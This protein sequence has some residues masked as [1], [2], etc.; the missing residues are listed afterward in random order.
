MVIDPSGHEDERLSWKGAFLA[1]LAFIFVWAVLAWFI[2]GNM[3][4]RRA[5][6][7]LAEGQRRLSLHTSGTSTGVANYLRLLHGI[8]AA[9]GRTTE[10]DR[11]LKAFPQATTAS[12][13]PKDPRLADL[14]DLL[15]N[16]AEALRAVSVLWVMNPDG[17]CLAA[18]NFEKGDSFVGTSYKD[19]E[20]FREAMAGEA[21]QQFAVGRKTGVPGLFFSSP[22]LDKGRVLGVIAAKID[23]PVL[24]TWIS[25]TDSFLADKHGII[26]LA[27][28][29]SLEFRSLPGSSSALLTEPEKV[30]RYHRSQFK[31]IPISPWGDARFPGLVRFDDWA[32]P[33]LM[34][35]VAVPEDDLTVNVLVPVPGMVTVDRDRRWI[36]ALLTLL[37]AAVIGFLVTGLT[38]VLHITHAR[39]ILGRRLEELAEAASIAKSRFLATMSHEIRTPLNGVLGMADLL[40]MPGLQD[41]ERLDYAQTIHDSGNTLL[42]LINDILDLSKVEAGKMELACAPF[43][44]ARVVQEMASLFAEMAARK[45]L[46]LT[47]SWAST[48]TRCYLGDPM[49]LRQMLSNLINNAIKFTETGTIH[50]EGVELEREVSSALLEFTVTDTGMGVPEEKRPQLFQA[51]QQLDASDTRQ[52]AG[53]GLGLSIVRSLARLMGGD[54]T[55]D[56]AEGGGSLFRIRIR[57][58]LAPDLPSSPDAPPPEPAEPPSAPGEARRRILLV[59]DN[60]TNRKVIQALLHR[61]GYRVE[62]AVNG[63]EALDALALEDRPDLVLMDCQMPVLSGFDATEAIR[64]RERELGQTR[65]PIVALTAGAFENDRDHCLECGMD[66]FVTKPVDFKVLP[67]VIAKWLEG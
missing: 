58:A 27:R 1:S 34:D 66:D 23:L 59:E 49:R 3:G 51:F 13:L 25:Q 54:V 50:L 21:G 14:N 35:S 31:P 40:L 2:T 67:A 30:A 33:V 37:G 46:Q 7:A 17:E 38:Y 15:K 8:P 63:Q 53:T 10:V 57:C 32:A 22:V 45:G 20:Y 24:E 6:S 36:F 64:R 11:V 28:D 26:I 5:Q 48:P 43:A 19:R 56:E 65:I 42:T 44:P 39:K 4:R 9:L 61:K 29:K 18:S 16:S 62:C 52:F 55:M 41:G 60:P 12:G 47:G